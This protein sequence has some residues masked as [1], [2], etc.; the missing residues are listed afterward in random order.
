M[1]ANRPA[2]NPKKGTTA[3]NPQQ[4]IESPK[5]MYPAIFAI[6]RKVAWQQNNLMPGKDQ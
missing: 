2:E 5:I 1:A 3:S 6:T 4:I